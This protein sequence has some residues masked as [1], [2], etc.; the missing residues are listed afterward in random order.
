MTSLW[1]RFCRPRRRSPQIEFHWEDDGEL[2]ELAKGCH[3][4][5][6]TLQVT[7]ALVLEKNVLAPVVRARV[8]IV[9]RILAANHDRK[10]AALVPHV[11][12]DLL[13]EG[14]PETLCGLAVFVGVDG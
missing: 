5:D 11:A 13:L 10:I 8:E 6:P 7:V 2:I 14:L 12:I 9:T 3:L 4:N 1:P